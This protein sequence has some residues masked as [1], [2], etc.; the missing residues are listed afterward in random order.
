MDSNLTPLVMEYQVVKDDRDEMEKA[1]RNQMGNQMEL[2]FLRRDGVKVP[3]GGGN[4]KFER[5]WCMVHNWV[6][7][8]VGGALSKFN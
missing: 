1:M 8:R 4:P 6:M 2:I 7:L 3:L 5:V